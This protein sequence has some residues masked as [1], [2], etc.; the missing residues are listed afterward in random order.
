MEGALAAITQ[1]AFLPRRQAETTAAGGA[2]RYLGLI[3][4]LTAD[5]GTA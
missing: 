3:F 4:H 2:D 5:M 1:Q